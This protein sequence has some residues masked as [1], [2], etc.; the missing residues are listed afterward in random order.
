MSTLHTEVVAWEGG[1]IDGGV[2]LRQA[3]VGARHRT[4]PI[5]VGVLGLW[6]GLLGLRVIQ[7]SVE[8]RLVESW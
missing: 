4:G 7:L 1:Y 8:V 6:N 2:G 5:G 3:F